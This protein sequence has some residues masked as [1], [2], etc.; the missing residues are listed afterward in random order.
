MKG[1]YSWFSG[2]ENTVMQVTDIL[3]YKCSF[4]VLFP[5]AFMSF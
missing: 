2:L 4:Y 5:H 1:G 3:F